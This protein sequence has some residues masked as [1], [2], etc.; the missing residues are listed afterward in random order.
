MLGRSLC[1]DCKHYI[2]PTD[3][4]E[5]NQFE[6]EEKIMED[7]PDKEFEEWIEEC[8]FYEWNENKPIIDVEKVMKGIEDGNTLEEIAL[9]QKTV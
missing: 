9:M 1:R 2:E 6:L 3:Y 5:Q 8:V 7:C 4:C